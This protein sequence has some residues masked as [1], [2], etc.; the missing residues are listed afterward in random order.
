[1]APE[2]VRGPEGQIVDQR[3]GYETEEKM[4]RHRVTETQGGRDRC[5]YSELF[6]SARESDRTREG[7]AKRNMLNQ[8]LRRKRQAQRLAIK[9]N[10]DKRV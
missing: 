4:E 5:K 1:M 3:E 6:P 8:R 10:G 9:R 7:Q 2:T